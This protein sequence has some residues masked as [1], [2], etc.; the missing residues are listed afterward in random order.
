MITLHQ[1]LFLASYQKCPSL[2]KIVMPTQSTLSVS[3]SIKRSKSNSTNPNKITAATTGTTANT[4]TKTNT[5]TKMTITE[6]ETI[7]TTTETTIVVVT[8]EAEVTMVTIIET[9]EITIMAITTTT[10]V[11]IVLRGRDPAHTT[12]ART[13]IA[14]AVIM[15][16]VTIN[17]MVVI[18]IIMVAEEI[19]IDIKVRSLTVNSTL[20]K[21]IET[22][23]MTPN[24]PTITSIMVVNLMMLKMV[25]SSLEEETITTRME[26]RKDLHL[27]LEIIIKKLSLKKA[28]AMINPARMLLVITAKEM[29]LSLR[30]NPVKILRILKRSR[31][32]L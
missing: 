16:V 1:I 10:T 4:T 19:T 28:R 13:E 24:T 32:S 31:K 2:R 14:V 6:I 7:T 12:K 15:E 27:P 17:I 20:P 22:R 23:L 8:T 25:R 26:A 18:E 30:E 11:K 3:N 5:I 9:T 29:T 21:K